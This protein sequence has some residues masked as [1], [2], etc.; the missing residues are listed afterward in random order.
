MRPPR[1]IDNRQ[2]GKVIDELVSGILP[3]ARLFVI[4][5]YFI[6]Y[7]YE[8]VK[9]ELSSIE[10]MR[11]FDEGKAALRA[12]MKRE[13]QFN[14]KM[15]LNMEIQKLKQKRKNITSGHNLSM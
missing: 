10:E 13:F 12:E 1:L 6:I 9:K 5:A 3:K 7:A 4:S 2:Q 14:R 11:F 15:E 8:T